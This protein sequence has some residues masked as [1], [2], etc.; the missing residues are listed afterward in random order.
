MNRGQTPG[1]YSQGAEALVSQHR[2][3]AGALPPQGAEETEARGQ[4]RAVAGRRPGPGRGPPA[5]RSRGAGPS[6]GP[7]GRTGRWPPAEPRGGLS[8]ERGDVPLCHPVPLGRREQGSHPGARESSRGV[9]LGHK[10]GTQGSR[11]IW[12]RTSARDSED[13]MCACVS[14][15]HLRPHVQ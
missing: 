11:A 3:Q 13:P 7:A 6:P 8:Q 5:S 12:R 15:S 1:S 2:P 4:S 9:S 10:A 14:L